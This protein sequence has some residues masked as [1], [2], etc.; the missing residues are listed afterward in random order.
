MKGN[1]LILVRV[2]STTREMFSFQFFVLQSLIGTRLQTVKFPA[3]K[4][5]SCCFGGKDYSDLYVTSSYKGMDDAAMAKQPQAG[6]IFKVKV[7]PP[8]V[9]CFWT[10]GRSNQERNEQGVSAYI[11]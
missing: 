1:F 3:E 10:S 6:C 2:L 8:I 9:I 4:I 7:L 5:T 11:M